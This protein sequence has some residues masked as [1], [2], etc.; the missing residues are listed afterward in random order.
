MG[1]PMLPDFNGLVPLIQLSGSPA[2]G[3]FESTNK[4][5]SVGSSKSVE[6]GSLFWPPIEIE[7]LSDLN[8]SYSQPCGRFEVYG[9]VII[10]ATSWIHNTLVVVDHRGRKQ[11]TGC[12]M[13][14][15]VILAEIST[16]NN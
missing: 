6:S 9:Y 11:A 3:V 8:I 7:I 5:G 13:A 16:S 12:G 4:A 14:H 1:C 2:V 10:H 15:S